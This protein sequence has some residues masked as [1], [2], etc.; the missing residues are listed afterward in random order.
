MYSNVDMCWKKLKKKSN[1][2][3]KK[4]KE[5]P[6]KT[7]NKTTMRKIAKVPDQHRSIAP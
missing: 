3:T 4:S 5:R 7:D 2:E 6:K 1:K